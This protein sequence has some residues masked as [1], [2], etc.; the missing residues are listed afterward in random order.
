MFSILTF[1]AI[2]DEDTDGPVKAKATVTGS[3]KLYAKGRV[4]SPSNCWGSWA[5]SVRTGTSRQGTSAATYYTGGVN[6]NR[7]VSQ[8]TSCASASS[9]VTGYN[10]YDDS[11][12]ASAYDSQCN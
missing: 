8:Y 9:R 4:F 6:R 7:E 12:S 1:G 11:Y 5:I 3:S 2:G 10:S